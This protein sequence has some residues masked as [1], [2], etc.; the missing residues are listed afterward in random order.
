MVL[1]AAGTAIAVASA[2]VAW[3]AP[4]EA[5]GRVIVS[6]SGVLGHSC[7]TPGV[8]CTSVNFTT[9]GGPHDYRYVD[10][11]LLFNSSCEDDCFYTIETDVPHT[12]PPYPP[13]GASGL[14]NWSASWNGSLHSGPGSI[15]VAED[16]FCPTGSCIPFA[17]G[18]V[19]ALYDAGPA[20]GLP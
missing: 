16:N 10:F 3:Q 1:A 6:F 13:I 2:S 17:L 4:P 7:P 9:P 5:S 11:R 20:P 14:A 18:V 8:Y 19:L 12:N 15:L